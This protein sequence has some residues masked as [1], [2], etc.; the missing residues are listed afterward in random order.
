MTAAEQFRV[1]GFPMKKIK[2]LAS[3]TQM[4]Q[5]AGNAMCVPVLTHILDAILPAVLEEWIKLLVACVVVVLQCFSWPLFVSVCLLL[6]LPCSVG[7]ILSC[8]FYFSLSSGLC[9]SLFVSVCLC[10]LCSVVLSCLC[11][12]HVV[13]LGLS[14]LV[15]IGLCLFLFVSVCLCL[16]LLVFALL[17]CCSLLPVLFLLVS[18]SLL[19]SVCLCLFLF[20][21]VWK[22]GHMQRCL[23]TKV[24]IH[25]KMCTCTHALR[26]IHAHMH[27]CTPFSRKIASHP[28]CCQDVSHSFRS[29]TS[30]MIATSGRYIHIFFNTHLSKCADIYVCACKV[31]EDK[32]IQ[33]YTFCFCHNQ[34][35]IT[36]EDLFFF[37]G[38]L[39]YQ[40]IIT[41]AW[42]VATARHVCILRTLGM[43]SFVA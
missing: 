13:S 1:Q 2:S 40:E 35:E 11:C 23:D 18:W 20:V 25:A 8:L 17:C 22:H 32:Y 24:R 7:D 6:F 3:R 31:Y 9:L 34:V 26:K 42:C 21:A 27:T 41:I 16:S 10:L 36:F 15:S 30:A 37:S 43:C 33:I 28:H 38:M 5:L 39:G 4:G 29:S 19:V 14:P 12:F